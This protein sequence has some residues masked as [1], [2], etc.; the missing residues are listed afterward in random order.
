[1]LQTLITA[2]CKRDWILIAAQLSFLSPRE[3]FLPSVL[4]A[5]MLSIVAKEKSLGKVNRRLVS[6][7]DP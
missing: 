6:E 4:N 3:F 1:M 5:M 2:Q 7:T